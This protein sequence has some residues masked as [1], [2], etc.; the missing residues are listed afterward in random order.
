MLEQQF[1]R[2]YLMFRANY[3][4]RMVKEIGAREGSLSATESYCVEIIHLMGYPTVT[5]FAAYLNISAPN[6]NYKINSLVNKGYVVREQSQTDRREQRLRVTDKFLNYYGLNDEVVAELMSQ[7][8]TNFSTEETDVLEN[9][10]ARITA[11]ME[12][13]IAGRMETP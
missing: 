13:A 3:Y 6:A 4:R 11:L 2:L 8:K 10:L 12:T 7:I 5:Q 1:D 9:M